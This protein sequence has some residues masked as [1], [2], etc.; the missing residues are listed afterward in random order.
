MKFAVIIPAQL[1]GSIFDR[2][3]LQKFGPNNESILHLKINQ[4]T[5]I[6]SKDEIYVS[7]S[8]DDVL[9]VAECLGVNIHKRKLEGE[10]I[11]VG[12]VIKSIVEEIECDH[13]FWVSPTLPFMD[14]FD[15]KK[16]KNDYIKNVIGTEDYD[17]LM[18]VYRS[19]DYI[20]FGDSVQNYTVGKEQEYRDKLE[21]TYVVTNGLFAC[22]KATII[23]SSYY[24]GSSVYK[25][26][27]SK[28][29]AQDIDSK[30]SFDIA[31]S[32]HEH[33]LAKYNRKTKFVF[34]DF[35]G[36]IVDSAKEA[37]AMAVLATGF[38]RQLKDI[39]FDSAHCKKFLSQR[40]NIGP[41]WNYYYLLEAIKNGNEEDFS[42][43]LPNEPGQKAREFQIKFFATRSVIREHFWDSWLA[44]NSLYN[45]SG[46]FISLINEMENIAIVTTKDSPTVEALL[47]KYGVSKKVDIFDSKSYEKFGCKSLFMD[48]YIK[49]KGIE[50][51]IFV[52]D[53]KSHIDKCSWVSKLETIQA[54]W[55]YVA[56]G[57]YRDNKHEV[58]SKITNYK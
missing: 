1:G 57:D 8:S 39:D 55:G 56:P 6:F 12:D 49:T 18:A 7:S 3:P 33:Y 16:A 35:D 52:D 21:P 4:L 42:D 47:K 23:D 38:Y 36:V 40:Y 54:L 20:W 2:N 15:Y 43:F 44:L 53:S 25:S 31:N 14:Q 48:N 13:V 10:N 24:I 32:L 26:E 27:F 34:L 41:A 58:L 45:G 17:S 30:E 37:Y 19:H 51:A 5:K 9:S 28:L 22:P 11:Y 50:N 46:E 29:S